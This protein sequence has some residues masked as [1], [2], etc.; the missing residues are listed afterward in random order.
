MNSRHPP[1]NRASSPPARIARFAGLQEEASADVFVGEAKLAIIKTGPRTR[2]VKR[3]TPYLITVI[4]TGTAPATNVK[5]IDD[6]GARIRAC[7]R[8]SNSKHSANGE[9]GDAEV[10]WSLGTL[11]PGER[12]TV[13]LVI[14]ANTAGDL[15]NRAIASA[16]HGVTSG[17]AVS[18]QT[19]FETANG[20]IIEIDK[21]H[22]P[23]EVGQET[24]YIVRVWN[25]GPEAVNN[26]GTKISV[27]TAMQVVGTPSGRTAVEQSGQTIRF[28]PLSNLSPGE[29]AEYKLRVKAVQAGVARLNVELTSGDL[30]TPLTSEDTTTIEASGRPTPPTAPSCTAEPPPAPPVMPSTSSSFSP[31]FPGF[32]PCPR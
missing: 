9:H 23:V 13:Q 14:R 26:L 25:G 20:V 27:P 21:D 19:H 18:P 7:A 32:G 12:R 16:D 30:K 6:L 5:L 3:P 1:R 11:Q 24:S 4:N 10:K 22:D 15:K 31:R 8:T 29:E 2:A 17:E 28:A